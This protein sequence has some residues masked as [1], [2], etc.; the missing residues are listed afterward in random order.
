MAEV[1]TQ[2]EVE[3][4]LEVEAELEVDV[5][6]TEH[7][8]SES[9]QLTV[10]FDKR[11]PASF[12]RSPINRFILCLSIHKSGLIPHPIGAIHSRAGAA[13]TSAPSLGRRRPRHFHSLPIFSFSISPPVR[14]SV[15]PSATPFL[16]RSCPFPRPHPPCVLVRRIDPQK[17]Q[18]T[19]GS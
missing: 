7:Q 12:N 11:P 14:A 5:N 13:S 3:M 10:V 8:P 9:G 19:P 16:F 15:R 6:A 18:R 2:L 17:K 4:E 1:E